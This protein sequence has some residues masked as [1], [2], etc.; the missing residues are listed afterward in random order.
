MVCPQKQD[1]PIWVWVKIQPPGDRGFWSML[2]LTRVPF[3]VPICDPHPYGYQ[4]GNPLKRTISPHLSDVHQRAPRLIYAHL[5]SPLEQ[6]SRLA[7]QG[8]SLQF[9]FQDPCFRTRLQLFALL[10]NKL[11]HRGFPFEELRNLWVLVELGSRTVGCGGACGGKAYTWR[12]GLE[13][14]GS[15]TRA[16]KPKGGSKAVPYVLGPICSR[17]THV[18]PATLGERFPSYYANVWFDGWPMSCGHSCWLL[19]KP[20]LHAKAC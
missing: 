19:Q 7:A 5:Q 14:R 3:W 4:S 13:H 2:P 18:E 10:P 20:Q 11:K 8:N 17:A 6:M 9:G 16:H 12:T 15:E 1:T